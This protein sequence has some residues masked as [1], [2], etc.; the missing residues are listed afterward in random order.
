MKNNNLITHSELLQIITYDPSSGDFTWLKKMNRKIVVGSKA[1]SNASKGYWRVRINKVTYKAHA[2]AIFY[3]TGSWPD[4]DIDHINRIRDDNRFENLR[5]V[6]RSQNMQ[7]LSLASSKNKTGFVG[8]YID[9]NKFGAQI[10]LDG[11]KM[12]LGLFD[13]PKLAHCAYLSAKKEFHIT[14]WSIC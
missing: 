2:L 9:K 8:V 10:S 3:V 13:T 14:G 7:N 11:K 1:G 6:S 12:H 4:S 5:V